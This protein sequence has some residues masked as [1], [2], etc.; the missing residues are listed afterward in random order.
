MK[1]HFFPN[2][3]VWRLDLATGLSREF[4]LRANGLA[5]PGLLS[6]SAIV[7][8]T[9]QLPHAPYVCQLWRLAS[10]ESPA[11]PTASLY[12]LAQS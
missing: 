6:C 5:S 10:L 2:R 9:L 4:K 7:G 12:I 1:S 3:V 8:M 11:S